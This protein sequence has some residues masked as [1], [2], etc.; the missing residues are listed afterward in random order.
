LGRFFNKYGITNRIPK[1]AYNHK[2]AQMAELNVQKYEM[3]RQM[4][5][6][7]VHGKHLIYVE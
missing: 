1:Y 5:E 7:V 2:E 4:T 3:N 6:L